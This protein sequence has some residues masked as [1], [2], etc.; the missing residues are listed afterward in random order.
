MRIDSGD[1]ASLE[2]GRISRLS[3]T[4]RRLL[5]VLGFALATTVAARVAV[6]LPGTAVPF[7]LQVAAVLLAGVVMGPRFGAASQAVYVMAGFVGLPVFMAGGGPAYLLGP[8]GGYLI[9]F[10]AAAAVAGFFSWRRSG[11]AWAT[12]G[13]MSRPRT[14][15]SPMRK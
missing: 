7:T 15:K 12:A 1:S 3:R 2:A 13:P 6:P 10:P 8:T 14:A 11:I 5:A 4:E 9:A